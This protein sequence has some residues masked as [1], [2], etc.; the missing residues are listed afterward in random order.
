[1]ILC[2]WKQLAYRIDVRSPG[3][4]LPRRNAPRNDVEVCFDSLSYYHA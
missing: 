1:M 2:L 4:G 3:G